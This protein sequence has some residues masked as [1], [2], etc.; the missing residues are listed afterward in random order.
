MSLCG[1]KDTAT[2]M[3]SLIRIEVSPHN[4]HGPSWS[5]LTHQLHLIKA[6]LLSLVRALTLTPLPRGLLPSRSLV[7]SIAKGWQPSPRLQR[8]HDSSDPGSLGIAAEGFGDCRHTEH[9][10]HAGELC[11]SP[12]VCL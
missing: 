4:S 9:N 1:L 2:A 3:K 7:R 10:E 8:T 5:L 11:Q 12:D 6:D